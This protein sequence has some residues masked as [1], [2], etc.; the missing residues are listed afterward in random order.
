MAYKLERFGNKDC[1]R[2]VDDHG[3]VVAFAMAYSNGA[4]GLHDL[5]D[6]PL[7]RGLAKP[8]DVLVAFIEMQNNVPVPYI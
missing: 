2:I 5:N 1:Q 4:W 6:R 3:T 7:K 8:K